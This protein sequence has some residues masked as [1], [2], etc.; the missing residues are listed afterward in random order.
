MKSTS[1]P[2]MVLIVEDEPALRKMAE[3][4]LNRLGYD[5]VTAQ[6]GP[7]ALKLWPQIRG[8]LDLLFTD[9]MMPGG[10]TGR[11]LAQKLLQDQ[12]GLHVIYSTGYSVDFLNPDLNLVEGVNLLL[13]PY[14]ATT[15]T[16]AVKKALEA[17]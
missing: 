8:K 9:M 3:K 15:L 1:A 11:E 4:I 13:K 7:E 6:D 16:R 5:I 12:P 14:N 2:R 10:I 17:G